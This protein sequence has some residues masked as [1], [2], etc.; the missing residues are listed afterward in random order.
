MSKNLNNRQRLAVHLLEWHGGQD[1]G[2]YALGSSWYAGRPVDFHTLSSACLELTKISK[3]EVPFPDTVSPAV[4]K[5]V[6]G[7]R[8]K[9]IHMAGKKG[10]TT[11]AMNKIVLKNLDKPLK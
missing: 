2:L 3:K 9:V 6:L 11:Y 5:E 7:L 4:I 10:S 1:T 8:R